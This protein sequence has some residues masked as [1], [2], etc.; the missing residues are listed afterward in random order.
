MD[1]EFAYNQIFSKGVYHNIIIFAQ[2]LGGNIALTSVA[3]FIEKNKK[4]SLLVLDSTFDSY[5]NI[6]FDKMVHNVITFLFSPLC[7][8]LLSDKTSGINY[9]HKLTSIK[10]VVI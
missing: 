4:I 8:V 2:S 7:Y 6:A 3:K 9:L 5:Q 1:G 10:K